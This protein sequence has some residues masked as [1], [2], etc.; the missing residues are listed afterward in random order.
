MKNRRIHNGGMAFV[1]LLALTRRQWVRE[2]DL[3][4]DLKLSP[5]QLRQTLRFFEK[6]KLITRV[7][8]RETPKGAKRYK[9]A[10]AKTTD[11]K[12]GEEK[13]KIYDVVRYRLHRM[14]KILEDELECCK[15][16]EEYVCSRCKRRYSA[17]DALQL[18]SQTG[19]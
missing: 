8:R 6:E 5:K 4:K 16:V 9:V 11:G 12:E 10:V 2:D 18:I 17:L 13:K 3:A 15:T 1:V 19:E 7:N 14:K